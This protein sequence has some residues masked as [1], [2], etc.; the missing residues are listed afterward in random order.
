MSLE[1]LGSC[2]DLSNP[3]KWLKA[4]WTLS[5]VSGPLSGFWWFRLFWFFETYSSQ[6]SLF[7]VYYEKWKARSWWKFVVYQGCL[8][9]PQSR[10]LLGKRDLL[11]GL[12]KNILRVV[13]SLIGVDSELFSQELRQPKLSSQQC[14]KWYLKSGSQ[15]SGEFGFLWTTDDPGWCRQTDRVGVCSSLWSGKLDHQPSNCW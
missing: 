15:L 3:E 14:P 2:K 11:A 12:P 4:L 9:A 8:F 5:L 10:I 7:E 1:T 13:A 6:Q